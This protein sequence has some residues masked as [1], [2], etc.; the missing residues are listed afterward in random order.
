MQRNLYTKMASGSTLREA[1]LPDLSP[2]EMQATLPRPTLSKE[3][4]M[5]REGEHSAVEGEE[6]K[7]FLIRL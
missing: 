3:A 7:W 6:G 2:E 4:T 1:E 5:P